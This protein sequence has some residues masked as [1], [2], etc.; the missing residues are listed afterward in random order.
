MCTSAVPCQSAG[1]SK[2]MSGRSKRFSRSV[3]ESSMYRVA[4]DFRI[5][6]A[7]V[8][9]PVA[10]RRLCTTTSGTACM[11]SYMNLLVVRK[12]TS[13]EASTAGTSCIQE[14]NCVYEDML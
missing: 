4:S 12:E 8:L 2:F 9:I 5:H 7:L 14:K 3:Q 6:L 11:L 10:L 13:E 1:D